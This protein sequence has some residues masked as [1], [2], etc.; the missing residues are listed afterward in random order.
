MSQVL[1]PIHQATGPA[2]AWTTV[3]SSEA[4]PGV[5]TPLGW[6][7]WNEPCE[8]GGLRAFCDLGV[9][10]PDQVRM[11]P[12]VDH[13][14]NAIFYGRYAVSID[15][16]RGIGDR[17]PGTSA[18]AVE[19]QLMGGVRSGA[20]SHP[21]R[22]RY[23]AVAAKMPAAILRAPGRLARNRAVVDAWWHIGTDPAVLGDL[24][25]AP[26]R[27]A[28]AMGHLERTMR[29]HIVASMAAQGIYE[30]LAKLAITAGCPGRETS[31]VTGF[32]G[33]EEVRM[34]TDLWSV[35]RDRLSLE[36]FLRRHG[37]HGPTE[38]ELSSR[39][40]R[41]DPKPIVALLDTYRTMP[42]S[43]SPGDV[44]HRR[45][46]GREESEREVLALLPAYQRPGARLLFRLARRYI[47]LREVGKVAFL[48]AIDVARAAAR[49]IGS[50]LEQRGLLADADDVFYLTAAEV[51]AGPPADASSIVAFRRERREEYLT[52]E[53]PDRW[54]GM[55]EP[56]AKDTTTPAEVGGTVTGLGVSPGVVEGVARVV[57]DPACADLQ[58]GEIL[59]CVT[60]DPGWAA[61]FLAAGGVVT[62]IGS[63]MGHGAIVARELGI[64]CVANTRTGTRQIRSGDRIRVDGSAGTVEIL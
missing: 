16:M 22:R 3:N 10:T 1:D 14:V 12:A 61:L 57:D 37:Y 44:E 21:S 38:G 11:A 54:V 34:T 31:L 55:P 18:D 13:R 7:L 64:P 23:P 48:Q 19:Q 56:S 15:F 8:L 49:T 24:A 51:I 43:S 35:S 45:R 50:D 63:A 6:T 59:V 36:E 58:A 2:T 42:D 5:L 27:I 52:L 9:L 32:G 46:A 47:P 26:S 17:M 28:D 39:S 53:L 20:A 62:D 30:Q 41:E 33:M 29:I 40:W 60:T 25:G 4:L